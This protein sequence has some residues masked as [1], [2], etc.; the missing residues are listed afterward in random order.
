MMR[1]LILGGTVF[2][3]RVIA[4][5]ALARGWELTL[6]NRGQSNP[7]LFPNVEKLRGDRDGGLDALKNRQW[8]AVVDPSGY[9]PRL[10]GDSAQ[11]LADTVAHY[12]FISSISV[13]KDFATPGIDES[14]PLGTLED[15]SVEEINGDTYGPLKA[16]CEQAAETAMPGRVL[17]VRAG[18]IVG[19]YDRTDRFTYWP[20]RV[21]RGGRMI[22]PL[23]TN[24]PLQFI[25]VRDLADWTLD[26]IT[27]KAVGSYNLTGI[28]NSI[29]VEQLITISHQVS[30]SDAEPVWMDAD[31]LSAQGVQPFADLPFW[32]ANSPDYADM[33]YVNVDKALATGL[34]FRSLDDT[35]RD[36]LAWANSRP[37]DY[38]LRTG[39]NA[40]REAAVLAAW[41]AK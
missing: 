16:L 25:D 9:V 1:L 3:G 28:P 6:F 35:L 36:T 21:Q 40:E 11:L 14:Y 19:R 26:R 22:A 15:E 2:V 12:T 38:A 5:Q 7:D 34:S 29:T 37:A 39:I 20:L 41:D 24:S 31:F 32:L 17:N 13:Y 33:M 18:F 30:S 10:V 8:D 27:E 23:P 4:E